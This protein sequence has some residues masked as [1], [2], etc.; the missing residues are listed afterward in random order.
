MALSCRL[1]LRQSSYQ[2][3]SQTTAVSFSRIRHGIEVPREASLRLPSPALRASLSEAYFNNIHPQ[4]SCLHKF[5]FRTWE[6]NCLKSS[7]EGHVSSDNGVSWFFALMV[8]AIGSLGLV[9]RRVLDQVTYGSESLVSLACDTRSAGGLTAVTFSRKISG[10]TI[11][12]CVE[13]G[14]HRSAEKYH[15]NTDALTKEM[16]KSYFWVAYDI[17]RVVAFTLG[18]PLSISDDSI[19]IEMPLDIDDANITSGGLMSPPRSS[20]A[21]PPTLMTGFIHAIKLRRLW[22][23]ISYGIYPPMTRQCNCGYSDTVEGIWQELE[24]WRTKTPD[25]LDYSRSHPLSVF[26]PRSWFQLAYDHSILLLYR[27]FKGNLH[28]PFLGGLTYLYCLWR[29]KR[30][31]DMTR[32]ANVVT[33]CMACSTVLIIIAERW[34]LATSYRDIFQTLSQPTIGMVCNEVYKFRSTSGQSACTCPDGHTQPSMGEQVPSSMQNWIMGLDDLMI[35]Q[36]SGWLVQELSQGVR[37]V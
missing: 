9:L 33:K 29:S 12:Y 19:D 6:E 16:F 15:K 34:K 24:E 18:R 2:N 26:T 7:H 36:E 14:Y 31:R 5:T 3:Y 10:R 11:R 23:K 17:D 35:S 13:L 32:Q 21:D 1:S 30:V 27:H 25:Q 28:T 20:L 22:S 8:Y 37:E 4:Y